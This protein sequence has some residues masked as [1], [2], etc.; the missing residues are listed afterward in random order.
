MIQLYKTAWLVN[1]TELLEDSE[2]VRAEIQAKYN[3]TAPT[4]EEAAKIPLPTQFCRII[5][6]Q[7]T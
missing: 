3:K 6:H 7:T 5:T 4:K 1:G 2:A